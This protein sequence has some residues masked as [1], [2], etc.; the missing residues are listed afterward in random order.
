MTRAD[1]QVSVVIPVHNAA[2]YLRECLDSVVHQTLREIEILCVDDASTDGS[3]AILDEYARR[4]ERFRLIRYPENR[5]ASQA[6]KDGVLASRGEYIQFLDADDVFEV[7]AC[8]ELAKRMRLHGVDLLQYG[9]RVLNMDGLPAGD[10]EAMEKYLRPYPGRIE[11][12]D[13]FTACFRDGKFGFT[14]CNKMYAG[15]FCRQAFRHVPD[16][17]YPKAQDL[18]AFFILAFFARSYVGVPD[19]MLHEYRFGRGLTGRKAMAFDR[20]AVFCSEVRVAAAIRR[21]LENQGAWERYRPEYEKLRTGLLDNLVWHWQT[22]L[23]RCDR[24]RGFDLL[25]E[26]WGVTD[27]VSALA[28]SGW[29]KRADVAGSVR[30]GQT[31]ASRKNAIRT[32]GTCYHRLRNGGVERVLSNLIPLW[33]GLGYQVVLFTNEPP[34]EDDYPLPAGV[35]RVVLTSGAEAQA[36]DYHIRARQW[37]MALAEN[38]IDVMVYH[39]WLDPVLLMDLLVMKCRGIPFIIH[40]HGVFSFLLTMQ[41]ALFAEMP[42]TFSLCDAV[43][44]LSRIDRQYWSSFARRAYYLPNPPTFDLEEIQC[45][46][47]GSRDVLWVGRIS[48]EKNPLD[49]IQIMARVIRQVPAARL[50][51]LGKG[52]DDQ[53]DAKIEETIDLL[54]LRGHVVLCGYHQEVDRYYQDA[55]LFLSTSSFEGFSLTLAES[56]SHG[57]PCVMYDMPHLELCRDNQG[58]VAVDHGDVESAAKEIVYLL[59]NDE[60]RIRMGREARRRMEEFS[61]FDLAAGWQEVFDSVASDGKEPAVIGS[62]DATV[63]I[64]LRTLLVHYQQ[65]E[66]LARGEAALQKAFQTERIKALTR[67]RDEARENRSRLSER[68]KELTRQRDEAKENRSRLSE[69]I[70]E[71]TRQRGEARKKR[72]KYAASVQQWKGRAAKLAARL[73]GVKAQYENSRSWKLTATLRALGRWFGS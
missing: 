51:M 64:M 59:Q 2:P 9:L 48:T 60:C 73:E 58:L 7:N 15:D 33:M 34:N 55:A 56:M 57:L 71:L 16:G 46:E 68:I 24:A 35:K 62:A 26:N 52:Q 44:A 72:D 38:G 30:G 54:G 17:F 23:T 10:I 41:H 13:V 32:I 5:S 14:L 18:L 1:P 37:E 42:F 3:G 27:V 47:L 43:V 65:G 50:L 12:S 22:E 29:C 39:A 63:R 69:R 40:A 28:K 4:D 8:E 11:G 53:L 45:S 19:L 70:K 66:E 6:R 36:G 20:F 49:A 25:V 31:L 21:F 61:T 67:Q